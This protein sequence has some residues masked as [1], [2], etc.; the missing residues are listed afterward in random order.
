MTTRPIVTATAVLMCM[1]GLLACQQ[2]DRQ[3]GNRDKDE[4]HGLVVAQELS[5]SRVQAIEED[6]TGQLWVATFRGLN[7]YDGHEYHQYFCTDDSL[8]LP[9]NNVQGLLCD[10][11][12]RLWVATVNGV[13]RYTRKDNFERIPMQTGNKNARKLLMDSKGRIFAYNGTEVMIYDEQ[14]DIFLPHISREMIGQVWGDF[15]ID[16]ADDILLI[17]PDNLLIY[18]GDTFKQR[19]ELQHPEGAG[20]YYFGLLGNG[21]LL[22]SGNGTLMLFDTK[23]RQRVP[24]SPE[25]E[26]RLLANGSAVQAACLLENNTILLS[27]SKNGLFELN[28]LAQTLRGE[29]DAGFTMPVPDAYVTHIFEDSRRNIWLG[30][31]DKGIFANYYYKEKFGGSD[32]YLNRVIENSSVLAV[33]MDKQDNLWISTMLKGVF[34]YHTATQKAE[35]IMIEGL[36]AGETKNAIN[37][38]FCDR[39]GLLWLST[40]NIVMKCQYDGT[41]LHILGQ[42]PVP[43][44][45]DFEQTDDGTVWVSTASTYIL[46]FHPGSNEPEAKQAFNVDYTFIPSLQKLS[47]GSMLI[48]AFYQNIMKMDPQTGK[49]TQLEIP[50]MKKCIRRSVFI[51]TDMYQDEQGDVWIGTVSNG[52]LRYSPKTN[53]MTRIAGL[54]CSDV[55]SIEKGHQGNLWIS[56][57]KGLN[58]LDLKTGRITSLYKA[59]GLAG[60]EFMDR[61]SCQLPNGSL[62]FGG[63]DGI[64]MF[65]PAD[66]D[67]LR[68]IPLRLCHLKIHNQLVHPTDGGPIEAMLDSCQEIRLHHDQNSF[69]I[70]FTALDFGEYERVHYYYKL[71][72][73][74]SEWI[75]A[76]NSH[77]AS[78][79]NLPSGH[80]T[81]RVR[82][83]DS[84][85][86]EGNSDERTINVIVEP[87]P[88]YSWWAW[89]IYLILGGLLA[90]YLYHNARR[91]VRARRAARQAQMEK[92]QEKRVNAMNM[93]FFANIAHEFRTPLTMIAGPVGQL[94]K[95][96][97]LDGEERSLLSIAQRSIQRMFKLVNQIMDFN[98][99]ENDTLRLSVEQIDVVKVMND[100]LDT[101]EF[102]AKEKGITIHR[103]GME[104]KLL[105]WT[106][107]DK[108]EKIVS[109]LLSNALKFTPRDGHIDVSLDTTD[110][111]V[112][113]TV[114]DTGKGIP[115]EQQENIFKRYYQLDNQTKAI[116]NWG[117]GIGLYY[118]RR[119]AELHHG[120]L[121]AGNRKEGTG[122]VFTLIYPMTEQAYTAEE[123]RPLEGDG[124]ADYRIIDMPVSPQANRQPPQSED[125]R[126]TILV[127]DDDTEIIN[128]MRLLFSQDYHLITCLDA[129]TALEEMRAEEPNIV[130]SDVMMPGKD[131]YELCQEIKQD[132]QLSHIPVILVTAKIT[133]ENQVEGLNVGADA[134]VTKPF[135]PAVLSA[136]IQSQL[137]NR[138][139]VRKLLTNATTTEEEGVENALSEQDK[140]FMEELYKLMEEELS[141]SELDVTRITKMLYISRTKLYYKIKGLTGETP[142]NFFRTYKLNRAAELLKSGRY[143]IAEIADKTGFSTQSHFSVVFK[144]QFGVT[145]SDYK[146]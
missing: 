66:I 75:D 8:G 9:D 109:N 146:G 53:T 2:E 3:D 116:V 113:V 134:Y 115:E 15:F 61:A 95:S 117:T 86:D 24:I 145:P 130:L 51:P 124:V 39:G 112:E 82:T 74:D 126:P 40:N 37:H 49:L 94:A 122:A 19:I 30:T 67:T 87:A 118:S 59:D 141:N 63:T 80:Y 140:H 43:M 32:N 70:S 50:D 100:I 110:D 77:S 111:T 69:S 128:Y 45:M 4:E 79:A 68:I 38:I 144:K 83:T 121:T 78:Y 98:K 6:A 16:A 22:S 106:D 14:H 31:Y 139:R 135:E 97:S 81:F 20:F 120:S 33:A 99:L 108:L 11:Q 114:A 136:L 125:D 91:L 137:K 47:D 44:T 102:N 48:A 88:A 1:L 7:R 104:D 129:D 46:G 36:P 25:M 29:G 28:L 96:G 107:G 84:A 35:E 89:L 52:L 138:E 21:L 58:R 143:T 26:A 103:F 62:V 18:D 23:A 132:I 5:N 127:V 41:R 92:E 76:G 60:D 12:G 85:S 142:S 42:W 93:S 17:G 55:A 10:K 13:C 54:S 133:A 27:T 65:N 64:T 123:R 101:F 119:L 71:D 90:T 57:M 105:A 131:G 34:V 73:F 72:G 56:T